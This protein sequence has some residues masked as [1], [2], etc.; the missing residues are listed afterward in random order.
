ME[1]SVQMDYTEW[2][3]V[4]TI[5]NVEERIEERKETRGDKEKLANNIIGDRCYYYPYYSN[6][7][8]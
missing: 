2:V 1:E 5:L 3:R 6:K 7:S 4:R 8:L